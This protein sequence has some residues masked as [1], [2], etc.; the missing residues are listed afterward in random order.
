MSKMGKWLLIFGIIAFVSAIAFG[1]SVAAFG[2]RNNDWGVNVFGINIPA[3]GIGEIGGNSMGKAE[4]IF[5]NNGSATTQAFEKS[6]EYTATFSA[7]GLNDIRI[8]LASCHADITCSDTDKVNIIYKTGSTKEGFTAQLKDG[9]L[10]ISEDLVLNIFNFGTDHSELRLEIPDTLY[11]SVKLELASGKIASSGI[12]S[13]SFLANVASGS[14]EMPMFADNI[15]LNLASGKITLTDRTGDAAGN[16]KVDVASG[17]VNMSGFRA[18]NTDVNVASGKV[19]LDGISGNVT[20]DLAS[21]KLD[22]TFAEWNGDMSIKLL[23][24][25]ADVT[26]PAGSGV[27]ASLKPL[28]GSMEI[29]LDGQNVK[30]K[31]STNATVGGSNVHNVKGDIASGS[32]KIHN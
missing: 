24:G 2:V 9:I 26:L 17:T 31:E 25:A 32:I 12:T 27:N 18:D 8:S 5:D 3:Y 13:D 22:M 16:I 28:S 4:I 6:K 7:E 14:V 10:D 20:G 11:N 19:V 15:K 1:I 21:G 30:L 23:S 29:N